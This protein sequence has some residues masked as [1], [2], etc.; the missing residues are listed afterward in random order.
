MFLMQVKC[1]ELRDKTHVP[2]QRWRQK[3]N[4][5]PPTPG[6]TLASRGHATPVLPWEVP[7]PRMADGGQQA[8]WGTAGPWGSGAAPRGL[9]SAPC[10]PSASAQ[11]P[12][13]GASLSADKWLF[14]RK[15]E[16]SFWSTLNWATV[17][18][19]CFNRCMEA[20]GPRAVT[21]TALPG[22]PRAQGLAPPSTTARSASSHVCSLG[23]RNTT[24]L[25]Q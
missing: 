11:P 23:F 17:S 12:S 9:R 20:R 4:I 22:W 3:N 2:K 6:D 14:Y 15:Y 13:Q 19:I 7:Q 16:N 5:Q 18:L 25:T 1:L 10:P 8:R 24:A 21:S